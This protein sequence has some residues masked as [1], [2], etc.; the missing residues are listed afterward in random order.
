MNCEELRE[1]YGRYARGVAGEPERGEIRAHLDGGCEVCMAG[2]KR[3]VETAAASWEAPRR[4]GWAPFWAAAAVLSLAAAA[5]FS[6]RERQSAEEVQ[7]LQGRLRAQ[8][9]DLVRFHEAF[10]ILDSP[11][12]MAAS[13]GGT[14]PASGA[15]FANREG[16]LLIAGNLPAPSAGMAFEMWVIP[17]G[18][19]PAPAG[20]FR[21]DA[22]GAAMHVSRQRCAP[23]DTVEVTMENEAGAGVPTSTPVIAATMPG[24]AR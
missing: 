24:A 20:M 15:V 12:A 23:G 2:V 21:P 18:A 4:F 14:Q 9:I 13:F 7:R 22:G 16:V 8:T 17:R 1:F 10:A 3:A 6:G 5:Y 11:G 19:R